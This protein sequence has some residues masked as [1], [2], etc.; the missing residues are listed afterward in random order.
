MA[1]KRILL[2]KLINK[3]ESSNLFWKKIK[4][5]INSKE[6]IKIKIKGV[7]MKMICLVC[8]AKITKENFWKH[9]HNKYGAEK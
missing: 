6:S 4:E 1:K 9:K 3:K 5:M 8:K 2:K 7:E